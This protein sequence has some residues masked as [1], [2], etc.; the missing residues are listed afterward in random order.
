MAERR[1]AR[2]GSGCAGWGG[3]EAAATAM[4]GGRP[5]AAS[6]TRQVPPL[7]PQHDCASHDLPPPPSPSSQL[8][9]RFI[10]VIHHLSFLPSLGPEYSCPLLPPR[11]GRKAECA[12]IPL[13]RDRL[14]LCARGG[15]LAPV[16]APSH[17]I[18]FPAGVAAKGSPHAPTWPPPTPQASSAPPVPGQRCPEAAGSGGIV[19]PHPYAVCQCTCACVC[20]VEL[21]M[22]APD[23]PHRSTT[24]K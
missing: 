8:R 9:C 14:S 20:V 13:A 2:G 12:R 3:G 23:E 19:H 4:A 6:C 11:T 16:P 7:C 22:K 15:R 10:Q 24:K 1:R 21:L 18:P 17:P 5:P